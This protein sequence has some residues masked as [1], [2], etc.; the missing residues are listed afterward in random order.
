MLTRTN[1]HNS[2]ERRGHIRFPV[3]LGARCAFHKPRAHFAIRC[4]GEVQDFSKRGCC[5]ALAEPAA[6]EVGMIAK[7]WIDW[8]AT[9]NDGAALQLNVLGH[10]VRVER[11][12]IAVIEANHIAVII[13]SYNF[14]VKRRLVPGATEARNLYSPPPTPSGPN[15]RQ[16]RH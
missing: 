10:V 1:P 16:N 7:L 11:N 4:V 6:V 9:L 13:D 14:R 15:H 8:P 2:V 12:H 5:L 3:R